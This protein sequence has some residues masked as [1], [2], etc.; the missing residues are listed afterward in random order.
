MDTDISTLETLL[1][2]SL[3]LGLAAACGF[4]VFVPLLLMSVAALT[5]H[6]ELADSLAWIGTWPA[7]TVFAVATLLEIGAYYVPW[8]DNFLDGVGVPAA[9]IAGTVV[10]ASAVVGMDPMLK[11]T[12]A[13]IAGGGV[14][15]IVHGGM[16]AVRGLSSL[17]TGGT[18]NPLVSTAEAG[19]SLTLSA[20]AV[21]IPFA[22]AALVT[23]LLVAGVA[24]IRRWRTRRGR[25][26]GPRPTVVV[27]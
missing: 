17:T 25:A 16:A 9:V 8:L 3:G 23:L 18:A 5:G 11:W 19:G 15:G 1:S 4:R 22:G 13:V 10:T 21:M 24:V 2:L 12:L 14:A 6:L 7:L 20:L 27:T 26:Q